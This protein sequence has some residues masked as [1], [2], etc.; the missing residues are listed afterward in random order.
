MENHLTEQQL[1]EYQFKL[2]SD[3]QSREAAEHLEL[4]EQ[5][6]AELEKLQKKFAALDLLRDDVKVSEDLIARTTQ[7]ATQPTRT[8]IVPLYRKTWARAIAAVILIG[9]L[10]L[11]TQVGRLDE[12]SR[13]VV[14]GPQQTEEKM[15]AADKEEPSR[16]SADEKGVGRDRQMLAAAPG[17]KTAD[18]V[19]SLVKAEATEEDSASIEVEAFAAMEISE[20]PPFAPA[21]AIELV[22]L[23]RREN[24]QL[25]IYNSSGTTSVMSNNRS[26]VSR[27]SRALRGY[28]SGATDFYD[29]S[30][31]VRVDNRYD[32]LKRTI[33]EAIEPDSWFELSDEGEGTIYIYGDKLVVY[34]TPEIH[35]KIE[36]LLCDMKSISGVRARSQSPILID[37]LNTNLAAYRHLESIV[38][39]S[40][41][42]PETSFSD[43][44]DAI[45]NSLL[46]PL[47]IAVLWNDLLDNANIRRD[48]PINIDGLSGIRLGTGLENLLQAFSVPDFELGY[49]VDCGVITI[50]TKESLP[51]NMETRVYDITGL[52]GSSNESGI[53]KS[54]RADE[55]SGDLV[56]LIQETIEP[57]SWFDISGAGEGTI[58]VN[59][60]ERLVIRQTPQIHQQVERLLQV[61]LDQ[62]RSEFSKAIDKS[63]SDLAV[64]EQLDQFVDLS[65]LK[66]ET[67]FSEAIDIMKNSVSPP[68]NV[69]VLWQDLL[70]NANIKRDTQINMDGLS[71]VRLE[72]GL[73]ILLHS[74][75]TIDFELGYVVKDGV[76]TIGT[77]EAL[78]GNLE[79]RVYDISGSNVIADAG[80][81]SSEMAVEPRE[82][83]RDVTP[84]R[85]VMIPNSLTLVRERRNLT[86]KKGWNWLQFMWANTLI[87][88]TS[89]SLEPLAQADK[90]E[91]QQLVFPARLRELGRWLVRSEVSGQVPFE[92][93]YLTSGLSWRAFYTGTLSQDEK[94]MRLDG[95]VRVANS[96]GED[97]E[98]AQT[99]MVVGKV[100]LLDQIAELASRQY[101]YG[102]PGIE[103]LSG[104]GPVSDLLL[105]PLDLSSLEG[106][107]GGGMMGGME[108]RPKEIVKEGL[109][110]YFLYTIEGTETIP[111]K[112]AKRL[113]SF[114]AENIEVDSL[115]KYDEQRWGDQTIRFVSFAN[116]EEHNLGDTPIPNGDVKIYGRTDSEGHLSYVGGTNIKYIPVNEEIELNLGPARLVKVEPKL[117]DFKTDNYMFDDRGNVSGWDEIRTWR[118][119]I[120]N[121]RTLPVKI[122]ITRGFDT[123]YWTLQ[124]QIEFV[125][126]DATHVRFELDVEQGKKEVLEYTVTTRHGSREDL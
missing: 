112:W 11:L 42:T 86:M 46:F 63:E 117:M 61:I 76:V 98:N 109:S 20:K 101:P 23:P 47:N 64:Y 113:L 119:E 22:T 7:Q 56:M 52:G 87:D 118:M 103:R 17:S 62:T 69:V 13:Q 5:C 78:P 37:R 53:S 83:G 30:E 51:N 73:D 58:S 6:R 65:G 24:V 102:R 12:S 91:I 14:E 44:I 71:R 89:L 2:D 115:Y 93:T 116:D 122:E 21:S 26:I 88:P 126:H 90:I 3:S 84:P 36:E 66:L 67:T 31:Y 114:E 104:S 95:Y 123:A 125:K 97:Y 32:G 99:R 108:M 49:V 28:R 60:N 59:N 38:D 8:K 80:R 120:T 48:T 29:Y 74:L 39:L 18:E 82:V 96:S 124:S 79:T 85:P 77:V 19:S 68:L 41:L 105:M 15:M 9:A 27:S 43:A 75:S 107:M 110:E 81:D 55:R 33:Q 45:R 4:C 34:Q 16:L 10:A 1:L 57:D 35:R 40:D 92:I 50:G 94:T 100:H 54:R 70:D 106:G 111:D 121:T 72:T 25:T